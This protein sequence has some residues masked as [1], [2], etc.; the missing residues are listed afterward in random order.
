MQVFLLW[1]LLLSIALLGFA[2]PATAARHAVILQYHHFGDDTPPSTSVTLSQFDAHLNYLEKNDYQVW[3]LEKVVAYLHEGRDLPERCVAMTID[4]AYA[5]TY[6]RAFSRLKA[7]HWPFTVFVA[8][9]AVDKGYR[10]LLTWQQMREMAGSGAT[11]ANHSS[12]HDHLIRMGPQETEE[13]WRLR[14]TQDIQRAQRRL[15]E[16]LG[17]APALFAYPYGE[18]DEPLKR[19]VTSLDLIAFGQQSGPAWTGSDFQALPRYAMSGR[20]ADAQEFA[21]RLRSLPLPVESAEPDEPVLPLGEPR[22]KLRLDLAPGP[23]RTESLACYVGTERAELRWLDTDRR[24]LE[25]RARR[26]LPVGRSRYNC[27]APHQ[28]GWRFFWYSH[29]LIRRHPNGSWYQE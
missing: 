29:L 15:R 20:Y 17:N 23:Y 11:F 12:T 21:V 13:Q 4:D 26:P 8:T 5:D 3:P 14:V 18:Y 7:R 2:I 6:T 28:D 1:R 16:E 25:V 27:T 24:I 22:P 10:G 9:D 19:L